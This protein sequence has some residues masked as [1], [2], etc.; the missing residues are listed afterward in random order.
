MSYAF[1]QFYD[2]QECRRSFMAE[3]KLLDSYKCI[4]VCHYQT[5][6]PVDYREIYLYIRLH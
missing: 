5:S 6:G 2:V 3:I 4:N 1:L